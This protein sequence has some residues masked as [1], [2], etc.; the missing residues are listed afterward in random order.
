MIEEK[1]EAEKKKTGKKDGKED[2]AEKKAK[3]EKTKQVEKKDKSSKIKKLPEIK[4]GYLVKVV[5]LS[6]DGKQDFTTEGTVLRVRGEGDNKT[7]TVRRIAEGVGVEKVFSFV[8]PALKELIV[9]KKDQ[10]RRS[11]LY[12]LRSKK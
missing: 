10:A 8:S 11:R 2:K 9:L 3:K 6:P 7:F 4:S 12:Y 1:K 5:H